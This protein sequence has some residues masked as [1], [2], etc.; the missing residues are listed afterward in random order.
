MWWWSLN[1]HRLQADQPREHNRTRPARRR[2]APK[3]NT[4]SSP[5]AV[6]GGRS[7]RYGSRRAARASE[8]AYAAEWS[9][10]AAHAVLDQ[11]HT[12]TIAAGTRI[13]AYTMELLCG[14]TLEKWIRQLRLSSHD[15]HV[16]AQVMC[17]HAARVTGANGEVER[18]ARVRSFLK[19][20]RDRHAARGTA[21]RLVIEPAARGPASFR[22]WL[23]K[24]ASAE[25]LRDISK[26]RRIL[27][28]LQEWP[29]GWLQGPGVVCYERAAG[30]L[31]QERGGVPDEAFV[32][33]LVKTTELPT[34]LASPSDHYVV[35]APGEEP[36][37][38][39]LNKRLHGKW[40]RSGVEE[41]R[42]RCDGGG[43]IQ[44]N[45]SL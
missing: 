7:K 8:R 30:R 23:A 44:H 12:D 17:A 26:N 29:L 9:D 18:K 11:I 4:H 20:L 33:G 37:F 24:D 15:R 27:Q 32:R 13:T 38:M 16:A 35:V 45:N 34:A 14:G 41:M 10:A 21:R 6:G 43:R 1:R 25:R 39:T 36:R 19:P 28:G 42:S 40:S 3:R 2:M 5:R 31:R 22:A